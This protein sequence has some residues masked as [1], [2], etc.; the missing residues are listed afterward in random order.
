M[1]RTA[2]RHKPAKRPIAGLRGGN[3]TLPAYRR[4]RFDDR[5]GEDIFDIEGEH[6]EVNVIVHRRD[7]ASH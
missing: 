3:A 6:A 5:A 4:D 1:K 7:R 2:F